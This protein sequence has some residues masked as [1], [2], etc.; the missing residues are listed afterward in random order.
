MDRGHGERRH[1]QVVL[2][3]ELMPGHS[4]EQALETLCEL[5]TAAPAQLRGLFDGSSHRVEQALSADDALEL[6]ERLQRVGV[7]AHVEKLT[8]RGV[9]L[10]LRNPPSDLPPAKPAVEASVVRAAAVEAAQPVADEAA[11]PPAAPRPGNGHAEQRWRAAWADSHVE[12]EP[13]ENTRLAMFVGPAAPSYVRRFNRLRENNRPTLRASWNW[14]AVISPFLWAL[15]RKLWGWALVIGM[16]EVVIPILLL[17]LSQHG[18]L[19][20]RFALLAYL[21]VVVNR[22]V[23]P[24]LADYLYFRHVHFSLIR[25]FRLL[26]GY[27]SDL[28]ILSAGG[29]SRGAVT[30][31]L[32]F[33]G[34]LALLM[35]SLVS[36]LG[37]GAE[38]PFEARVAEM[39]AQQ[40]LTKVQTPG[41]VVDTQQRDQRE[42]NRWATSRRKLRELGKVIGNWLASEAVNKDPSQ[43]TL[44]RLREEM[45]VANDMLVDGWGTEIHYL[46]DNEGYRLISAGP[47]QLFGTADDI[48]YRRVLNQ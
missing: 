7:R 29:V 48:L 45:G 24:L 43:L 21:S 5:F 18:A 19:P 31:G 12:E 2:A 13:D 3:G 14:G 8:D 42:E 35:W 44:F 33:S 32:A 36:S 38:D 28:D 39:A 34:V 10:V 22:I 15:Y 17:V 6:Q 11:E 20:E 25:L 26:P 16:T 27:V 40:D 4:L 47:D 37:P 46:P 41:E 9:P 1:Y 30:V 23:W